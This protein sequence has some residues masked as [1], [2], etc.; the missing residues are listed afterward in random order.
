MCIRQNYHNVVTE[1]V[2]VIQ[3]GGWFAGFWC[4]VVMCIRPKYHNVV[5]ALS[6]SDTL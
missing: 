6:D 3:R 5:M 4:A 1:I 2:G